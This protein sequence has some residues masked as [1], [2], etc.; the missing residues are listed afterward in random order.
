MRK[1]MGKYAAKRFFTVIPI[2][3]VI[4]FLSFGMMRLADRD[5]VLQKNGEYG[6]GAFPGSYRPCKSRA[7]TGQAV[8][9]PVFCMAW[10]SFTG[11]YG[12]QLYIGKRGFSHLSFKTAGNVTAYRGF[13]FAYYCD[14]HSFGSAG[15][16]KKN[17][18]T[19]YLIRAGSFLGNS[20]PNFFVAL[21]L[22]YFLAIRLN[23]SRLFPER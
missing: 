5:A 21:L 12:N 22:M 3:F 20:M 17:R 7:G 16:G 13:H 11:R 6:Y 19:D 9:Y 15:S 14:F 2:L 8:S 18:F 10:K 1:T 4:T 23:V